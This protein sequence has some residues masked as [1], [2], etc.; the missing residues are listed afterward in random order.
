MLSDERYITEL[1][2]ELS[3]LPEIDSIMTDDIDSNSIEKIDCCSQRI[4]S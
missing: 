4:Y 1:K 3:E 2:K